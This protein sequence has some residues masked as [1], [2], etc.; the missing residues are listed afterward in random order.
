[1]HKVMILQAVL[2]FP[3]RTILPIPCSRMAYP[4]TKKRK[5]GQLQGFSE[6]FQETT[7]KRH[8]HASTLVLQRNPTCSV[9]PLLCLH[10][11]SKIQSF[12]EIRPKCPICVRRNTK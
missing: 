8:K 10:D 9:Q 7:A 1:M 3:Y 12:A 11:L 2:P 4:K 5:R 6:L